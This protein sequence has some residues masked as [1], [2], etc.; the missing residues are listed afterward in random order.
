MNW[1]DIFHG[2][3]FKVK[4]PPSLTAWDEPEAGVSEAGVSADRTET[5]KLRNSETPGPMALTAEEMA[6]QRVARVTEMR[7][8][9][10]GRKAARR[11]SETPAAETLA[12]AVRAV[13][14][15][16][17]PE[18]TLARRLVLEQL[19]VREAEGRL[20]EMESRA[21]YAEARVEAFHKQVARLESALA[22]KQEEYDFA[23]R[24]AQDLEAENLALRAR[25]A[26]RCREWTG[27]R[28]EGD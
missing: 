15:E 3:A 26:R 18:A 21:R 12:Q 24:C 9:Y 13:E 22:F 8:E 4:T 19:K 10:T 1:R 23:H 25:L 14:A 11:N 27:Y 7:A 5:P 17:Q 6:A 20:I 28:R 16:G 2:P